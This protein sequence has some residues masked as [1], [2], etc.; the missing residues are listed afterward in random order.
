[1]AA[2]S[3]VG[4]PLSRPTVVGCSEPHHLCGW[5]RRAMT[6]AGTQGISPDSGAVSPFDRPGRRHR[7]TAAARVSAVERVAPTM[8]RVRVTG[9]DFADFESNGPADHVRVFFPDPAT[10]ALVAPAPVGPGEDGIVRPDAPMHA[11]DFTPLRVAR[12]GEEV[13]VDLDFYLY[14]LRG[15]Q[16]NGPQRHAQGTSWSSSVR[17]DRRARRRVLP[18][19]CSCAMR[20][21]CLFRDPL[22]R[23]SPPRDLRRPH[24]L[25][26]RRR[27]M[28][29]GLRR[30]DLGS[31]RCPGSPAVRPV[32]R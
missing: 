17:A 6:D 31:H 27:R 9:D 3:Q 25:H 23:R 29:V 11:R 18:G 28:G 12:L 1:M 15:R 32:E 5:R 13:H 24:R 21:R 26:L 7:F 19:W 30:C 8:L 22:G 2:A 10:G 14:R 4:R 20:R 16:P